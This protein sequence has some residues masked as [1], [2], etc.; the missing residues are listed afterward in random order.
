MEVGKFCR[1]FWGGSGVGC[2]R[3]IVWIF[4]RTRRLRGRGVFLER[5]LWLR[6]FVEREGDLVVSLVVL[7]KFS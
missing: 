3:D 7:G 2:F 6:V 4:R 1:V 5:V